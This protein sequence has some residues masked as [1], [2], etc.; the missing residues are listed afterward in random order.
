MISMQSNEV[1]AHLSEVLRKV[2]SGQEIAITRHGQIVARLSPWRMDTADKVARTEAI[3]AMKQFHKVLLKK[4][5]SIA[6]MRLQG[7]R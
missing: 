2:E 1:K 5:E 3:R 4:N 6:E 7:R